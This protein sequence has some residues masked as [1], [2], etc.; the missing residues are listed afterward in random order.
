MQIRAKDESGM[1]SLTSS[2]GSG[3]ALK[4]NLNRKLAEVEL[5]EATGVTNPVKAKEEEEE[6]ELEDM[7]SAGCRQRPLWALAPLAVLGAMAI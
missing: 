6:V 2:L 1:N 3:N 5:S 4:D 7:S